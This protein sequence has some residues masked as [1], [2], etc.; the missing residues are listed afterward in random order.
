MRK[1]EVGLLRQGAS[2]KVHNL[3]G[4]LPVRS[5]HLSLRYSTVVETE[6]ALGRMKQMLIGYL[7]A[8][9]QAVELRFSLKGDKLHN[10]RYSSSRLG[11]R[12][13][14]LESTIS[15]LFQAGLLSTLSAINWRAASVRTSRFSIRAAICAEP[16]PSKTAQFISVGQFPLQRGDGLNCL[17]DAL[18][19]LFEASTFGALDSDL[20][21]SDDTKRR[22]ASQDKI[23]EGPRFGKGVDRWPMFYMRV[24][25][26]T[27]ELPR[28]LGQHESTADE[29]DVIDHLTKAMETLV[30]HFLASSGF[31]AG[32]RNGRSQKARTLLKREQSWNDQNSRQQHASDLS[33]L[34]TEARYL[35]HWGQVKSARPSDE[36]FRHGLGFSKLEN[37][38]Y[39]GS[40]SN[41]NLSQDLPTTS[42]LRPSVTNFEDTDG[43]VQFESEDEIDDGL[44]T[45][46]LNPRNGQIV[47][48][49]P[50]TGA[51][52]PAAD[53][54]LIRSN[55]F[56]GHSAKPQDTHGA[57]KSFSVTAAGVGL[58][59]ARSTLYLQK[60]LRKSSFYQNQ[61]QIARVVPADLSGRNGKQSASE[62]EKTAVQSPQNI[63]K[64]SLAAATVIRQVDQK[65]ILVV[66]S[67]PNEPMTA[68]GDKS[69]LVLIDQHAAD[70]RIQY[71]QLCR[72][73][74]E[75]LSTRLA[76]P[77][78]FEV[79]DIEAR[80]FEERKQYFRGWCLG[81]RIE[82][83]PTTERS[84]SHDS[85]L[86]K[87]E[88]TSLPILIAERCR[89]EPKLLID[90]MRREIWSGS[91][92]SGAPQSPL[93]R[94]GAQS[95][96][97]DI[98]S[99][100][101]GIVE[102]LKSRSCRTAIMFNDVLDK[103][104]CRELV[105]KLSRCNFPFQCAH[106]RPTL[107]VLANLIDIDLCALFVG[108]SVPPSSSGLGYG[109][110]WKDWIGN[111]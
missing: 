74:C 64:E 13:F 16:C 14:S 57:R 107:S 33:R 73:L 50:R 77:L 92:S 36:D 29:L 7:L 55:T 3:F 111:R 20:D 49:H 101:T 23:K 11:C 27:T 83:R 68:A 84:N 15:V 88:V 66:V 65:F 44:A 71:E 63:S 72:G 76:R 47:R 62:S 25:T 21:V 43:D 22:Q 87:V 82:T 86:W 100:P 35:N 17:F 98:A 93:P 19:R 102:M 89:A 59:V 61:A 78:V 10:F 9:P 37:N 52:L 28:F 58:K 51:V 8:W 106:G 97:S 34:A 38:P 99:C 5:K 32:S 104:Q 80:L 30:S 54:N 67:A 95:W 79:N 24:D 110:A 69:V 1:E 2:V 70:E 12:Q 56:C 94:P 18:D 81:Y 75:R 39:P 96:W 60:Y 90:L 48:L 4:D 85:Q 103:S 41:T 26:S 53:Q 105:H 31:V 45:S 91:A 46:W 108:A 40:T 42:D 109:D 6:K